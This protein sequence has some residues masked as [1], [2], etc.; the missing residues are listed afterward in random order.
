MTSRAEIREALGEAI[1]RCRRT[2]RATME[3]GLSADERAD[4][5]QT[6]DEA[7]GDVWRLLEELG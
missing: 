2:T 4:A 6:D 5:H 3:P 1:L 7:L